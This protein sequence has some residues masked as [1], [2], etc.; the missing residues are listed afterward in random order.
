[1]RR[2]V[3]IGDLAA[4]AVGRGD[5][6]AAGQAHA[7]RLGERVHGRGGAHRVA[8]ADRGRGGRDDFHELLI[9]DLALGEIRARAPDDCARAGALA[10]M[11]PV[12][13]R[14]ARE[15]DRRNVDRRRRHDAGRGGLVAPGRQHHAIEK[16]AH[17]H[18][19]EAEIG[20][21]AVKRRRRP[22][23]RL[24]NGVHR[25]LERHSA[26]CRDPVAHALGELEVMAVAGRKIGAGLGDADDRLARAELGGRQAE[27]EI[28]L[29]IERRHARVFRI[30][31]PEARSQGPAWTRPLICSWTSSPSVVASL[32]PRSPARSDKVSM[33]REA[34]RI[35]VWPAW[36]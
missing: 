29:E 31:E 8:M 24:L 10:V 3:S 14:P 28:A 4:L 11:P 26:G 19:D 33:G 2:P 27:I 15:H 13:H 21:I 34:L 32:A 1:M 35:N 22:L 12:V 18:F 6:R 17:Q 20:E 23:A 5:R 36:G 7:E 16:I 30:V 25:K 9:V